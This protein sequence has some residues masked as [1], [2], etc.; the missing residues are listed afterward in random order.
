MSGRNYWHVY[1]HIRRRVMDTGKHPERAD[2]LAEFADLQA[3][4][5]D[6]GIAEYE[7]A[8]G[9]RKGGGNDAEVAE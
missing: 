9:E 8:F 1:N 4:V 3:S 2:L 7:I 6:E 5:V